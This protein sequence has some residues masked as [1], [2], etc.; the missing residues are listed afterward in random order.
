MDEETDGPSYKD[1]RPYRKTRDGFWEDKISFSVP[2][3]IVTLEPKALKMMSRHW[4]GVR[5][6]K[7]RGKMEEGAERRGVK[8]LSDV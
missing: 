1:A 7:G 5:W 2:E 4:L 8:W 3:P 6:R